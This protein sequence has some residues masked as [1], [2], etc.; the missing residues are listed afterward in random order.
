MGADISIWRKTGHFYFALTRTARRL[1]VHS[2]LTGG[3]KFGTRGNPLLWAWSG[4]ERATQLA[5]GSRH[6]NYFQLR[7]FGLRSDEDRNGRIR[8]LAEREKT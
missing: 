2:I 8:F 1:E 3:L 4:A 6:R 5:T 7:V